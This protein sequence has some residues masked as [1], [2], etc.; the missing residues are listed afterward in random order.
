MTTTN[1]SIED[2]NQKYSLTTQ[3]CSSRY[4]EHDTVRQSTTTTSILKKALSTT[5]SKTRS[6][7]VKFNSTLKVDEQEIECNPILRMK[8]A[9]MNK[10]KI[11]NSDK[12]NLSIV[13]CNQS[14][15]SFCGYVRATV[16]Q[17][18]S[19]ILC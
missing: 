2:T 6:K 4:Y 14:G 15:L 16:P 9:K 8:T 11:D 18:C 10:Q 7:T 12:T 17:T 19:Q 13:F 3:Y 1:L 5:T